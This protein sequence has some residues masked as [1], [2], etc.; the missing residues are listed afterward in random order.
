MRERLERLPEINSWASSMGRNGPETNA[1]RFIDARLLGIYGVFDGR[2]GDGEGRLA[3]NVAA[4]S[5]VGLFNTSERDSL[6]GVLNKVSTIVSKLSEGGESTGLI[7]L[8]QKPNSAHPSSAC[9]DVY[10]AN[11]GDARAY[12]LS[13]GCFF[14]A[15]DSSAGPVLGSHE[16]QLQPKFNHLDI[17]PADRLVLVTD[18][19]WRN[20]TQEE[21]ERCMI[22]DDP[23]AAI[24]NAARRRI[25]IGL[26]SIQPATRSEKEA[27]EFGFSNDDA[28]AVVVRF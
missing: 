26:G 8:V 14:E 23:A 15:I 27:A 2:R 13:D 7:A 17:K 24:V 4:D 25:G 1:D 9:N 3:A 22:E 12:L 10:L 5:F 20:L 11:V 19:I 16:A 28:T 6:K 21:I 18:G